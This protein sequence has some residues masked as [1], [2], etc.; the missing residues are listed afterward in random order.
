[1]LD[2]PYDFELDSTVRWVDEL[3]SLDIEDYTT[4]DVRLGWQATENLELSIVG[5]NLLERSN[6]EFASSQFVADEPTKVD[7]GVY[8]K[9]TIEF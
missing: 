8:G 1:M 6:Q 3:K 9:V 5:Q 4:L 2:L 7:R